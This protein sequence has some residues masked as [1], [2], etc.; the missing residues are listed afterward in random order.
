IRE[1][2][3]TEAGAL[4]ALVRISDELRQGADEESVCETTARMALAATSASRAYLALREPG[5]GEFRARVAFDGKRSM[6]PDEFM[7]STTFVD[8]VVSERVALVAMDTDQDSSLAGAASVVAVG[9]RSIL[10][11]PLWDGA[12]ILGYLYLDSV[13]GKS[14]QFKRSD[15]DLVTAIAH[16]AAAEIRRL[17]LA[18]RV[19][20]EESRRRDL[21]RFVSSDVIRVIEKEARAGKLDPTSAM[22]ETLCTVLF[23]DLVG[24][25]SL[26]E[27]RSPTEVKRLLDDY[28]AYMTEILVDKHGGTLDKFLGDGIMGLFGAPFS[29]G[30]AEDA[31]AAVAAAL[32]MRDTLDLLRRMRPD[33]KPLEM[34]IGINSGKVVA[35]MIGT[36]RRLEYTVIGDPV[37]VASRLEA[38]AEPG[39]IFIGDATYQVVRGEFECEP[40]GEKVVKNRATPVKAWRVVR[41]IAAKAK[42]KA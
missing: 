36:P 16:Q 3:S 23:A 20:D 29:R 22:Q 4:L 6:N 26:A 28:L 5:T 7:I 18:Q 25:T 39:S 9:I 13:V 42:T 30:V 34:R 24:F 41:S 11:V 12:E 37:N 2:P 33:Y 14:K 1:K 38:A 21:A 15:A 27:Q 31:R 40:E 17:R 10:C 8:K 19:R 32:E 35:G